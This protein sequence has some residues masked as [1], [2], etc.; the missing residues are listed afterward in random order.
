MISL[1]PILQS[2]GEAMFN[3]LPLILIMVVFYFFFI[4]PQTK[5]Q[6]AQAGFIHELQKGDEVVTGSGII[7]KINK[8]EGNVVHLQV[9]Q[10]TYIKVFKNAISN[11]MTAGLNAPASD[12]GE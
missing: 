4:R 12:K 10:K 9:D 6:K 3:F 8:I 2:G 1:F 11:E 7:G 5:K